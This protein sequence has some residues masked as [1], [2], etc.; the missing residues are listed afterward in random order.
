[1]PHIKCDFVWINFAIPTHN[2]R[3]NST[4]YGATEIAGVDNVAQA[5]KQGLKTR[6]WTRRQEEARVDNAGVSDRE[7]NV[8]VAL[9]LHT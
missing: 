6:A 9:S 5:K 3:S 2:A 4:M 7:N 8:L 1:M